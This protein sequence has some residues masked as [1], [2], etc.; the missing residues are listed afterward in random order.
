MRMRAGISLTVSLFDHGRL[1]ALVWQ[2]RFATAGFEGL[3]RDK[4]GFRPLRRSGSDCR[5]RGGFMLADPPVRRRTGPQAHGLQPNGTKA[6][7]WT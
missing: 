2:E 4:T 7:T 3:L 1:V 5:A 6:F